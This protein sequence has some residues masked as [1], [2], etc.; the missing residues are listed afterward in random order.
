MFYIF[1]IIVFAPIISTLEIATS[2]ALLAMT[3]LGV[4]CAVNCNHTDY[5]CVIPSVNEESPGCIVCSNDKT[6]PI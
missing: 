3:K 6:A 5:R 1:R 2:L 4:L